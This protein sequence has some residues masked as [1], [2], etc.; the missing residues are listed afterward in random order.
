MGADMTL[1]LR[2]VLCLSIPAGVG[3]MLLAQPITRLILER[4]NF[5]PE[6]TVRVAWLIDYYGAGVWANCAWPVVVRG[7]YALNDYRTPVRVGVW[8]V[9]L[10][11][12][13]NLTLIW[14]LGRGRIGP[15][16][17]RGHCRAVVHPHG[18]IL[19]PSGPA[20]LACIGRHQRPCH[21]CD[22]GHGRRRVPGPSLHAERRQAR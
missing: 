11:L 8:V 2:L 3:L 5:R 20:R 18:D 12:V 13:L 9:S 14:P 19:A 10:N 4:G 17:D 22:L 16:H 7:F 6:D 1:G 15:F 21:S